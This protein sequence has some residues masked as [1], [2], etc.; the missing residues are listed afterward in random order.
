MKDER[1]ISK[2]ELARKL[3]ITRQALQLAGKVGRI[4]LSQKGKVDLDG[5][6]TI[7]F[8]S[9]HT[10]TGK[11]VTGVKRNAKEPDDN[12]NFFGDTTPQDDS[13]PVIQSAAGQLTDKPE[14]TEEEKRDAV[15]WDDI[16][17]SEKTRE[18][19]INV[20][21]MVRSDLERQKIV[22]QVV[23]MRTETMV[24]RKQLVNREITRNIFAK[25]AAVDTSELTPLGDSIS[26]DLAAAFGEDDP[27]ARM[28]VKHI[29][30]KRVFGA[31][32]HRKRIMEDHLKKIGGE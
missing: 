3:G 21:L 24:K 11:L 5:P 8:I 13:D 16:R 32:R 14:F 25:L 28:K 7:A 12:D 6:N 15:S 29:V 30:D 4:D 10:K 9:T 19:K 1:Y 20:E 31:L 22:E 18:E 17:Q 23:K 2:A 26:G 27:K